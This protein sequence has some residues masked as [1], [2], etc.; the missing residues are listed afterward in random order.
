MRKSGLVPHDSGLR[1]GARARTRTIIAGRA[2]SVLLAMGTLV[3]STILTPTIASAQATASAISGSIV[4]RE[5]GLGVAGATVQLLSA[6][7]PV[8]SATSDADGNYRFPIAKPG[9]Y[10]VV[11]TATGYSSA[12]IDDIVV[13]AN[14]TATIATPL[15]LANSGSSESTR[16][17]G[18]T[19]ASS[20]ANA[21]QSSA[22]I[23]H[24]IDPDQIAAQGFMKAADAIGQ[25]PG[26]NLSGGP[27][28][29][30]DDTSINIRGM[31]AGET[32]PLIDG[33]P[34]GPI[35]VLSPDYYN[36]VN[37]PFS[38]LQN[39]QVTVGSGASGLYGVD[40]IGG[41]IDFQT[42]NPTAKPS[43]TITQEVGNDGTLGTILKST[44]TI[45]NLGYAVGHTV[46]GTYGGIA[47]QAIFQG[48]RPN[49]NANLPNG[50]ACTSSNDLSACNQALNTYTVSE[51][52][53]ALNDLV[54]L[55]YNFT[56]STAL[57]V[58][59]YAG[60]TFE[61]STGNGDNDNIPY[62]TQLAN[63]QANYTSDCAAG[64]AP[65]YTVIT[66]YNAGT[67]ITQCY[68]AQQYAAAASGPFGGGEDRHRGTS[69]QDFNANFTTQLGMHSI[70]VDAYSDYYN[71]HKY[72][73]G[74]AG[75]DP[76]G[77]FVCCGGGTYQDNYLSHGLLITDD[78]ATDHNDFGF[79]Y[80]VEHQ[81]QYGENEKYNSGLNSL[82][83]VAQ[84]P[85]GEGDYS[86]FLR[87]NWTPAKNLAVYANVWDR[88]S[89]VTKKTSLDPR[90]SVVFKPTSSDIVRLTTG[91]ADGDPA[92]AV[93]NKNALTGISN[94][95]SLNP[96]CTLPNSIATGGNGDLQAERSSDVELAYGH[97]FEKDTAIN[98]LG[99]V[100]SVSH[101]LFSGVG[102][103]SALALANPVIASELPGF[104]TKINSACGTSYTA[105][106]VSAALGLSD[107][108]NAGSALF[109]GIEI[110]GRYR[111]HP[112][113]A[114]DYS[115]DIESAQ[116]FGEPIGVLTNNPFL[117][118][119]GQINGVPVHKGSLSAD[120]T[121]PGGVEAQL[122][123]YYIGNNNTLN[124]PAYTFFNGFVSKKIDQHAT[125]V[126]NA[127]NVF[128]QNAQNYGYFGQQLAQPTNPYFNANNPYTGSI[129]Q[130]IATGL[131]TQAEEMGLQPRMINLSLTYRI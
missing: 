42:L 35:G 36:Y 105:Q 126:L 70:S 122:A 1:A 51:N 11:I 19:Q 83:F 119:G 21:L 50:G 47:P 60:N 23:Q 63:I 101:Q 25:L 49:N 15:L 2:L 114:F 34:V 66:G 82:S 88:Y 27:H 41:T 97:R 120:Y 16:V 29:V 65:G 111:V 57:T 95:S 130:A 127:E 118:D 44:G 6:G 84:Q 14:A 112:Q 5:G 67:P 81:Y 43:T 86:F 73:L 117:L 64:S 87:E 113:L 71:F 131:A 39:I 90:V 92:A 106:T 54:K 91:Q 31:G 24:N 26:V 69:L 94:P 7:K 99:Y 55:R 110:A 96:S 124:R 107:V 123:G 10:S 115:W 37:S 8:A 40:V 79:G 22:T 58:S 104:A 12:E 18:S 3:G 68:T 89:S 4:S 33:H 13:G 32:R 103:I 121:A 74:A 52:Y 128:N 102:P 28:T 125:L 38:L 98:V 77:T 59:A 116:Q 17:I 85:V 48:A 72:S 20:H 53:K 62:A 56:P 61:D 100:S 30:G 129:G 80:F 75:L 45:G 76:T 9:V 108:F 78:I 46:S 109:R 93:A